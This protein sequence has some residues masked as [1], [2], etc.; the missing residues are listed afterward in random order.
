M[1][2]LYKYLPFS[3]PA[4]CIL[5]DGTIKFSSYSEFNDPFDCKGNYDIDKS[6]S[7]VKRHPT[8]L[9]Q[10][11]SEAGLSPAQRIQNKGKILSRIS[12]S[13]QTGEHH[14]AIVGSVGICCLSR[15]KDQILMWSHY[16]DN[17]KGFVVEFDVNDVVMNKN[18]KKQ[19]ESLIGWDIE[20]SSS[21]PIIIVGEDRF[22]AVKKI[23]LTKSLDWEYESEY[24]A[25]NM[26]E[27]PG[28]Y[29][30]D[31][32]IITKVIAGVKMSDLDY[33]ELSNLVNDLSKNTG[34]NPELIRATMSKK[35][36]KLEFH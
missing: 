27:G 17:H 19:T 15:K 2:K 21:M 32:T 28:V 12:T 35:E 14:E 10:I 33:Q 6:L 8:L 1:P 3:A 16:A 18:K 30:F 4:K 5:S 25:L 9:K 26:D 20:Y 29:N 34:C 22:D 11:G 24:R 36:Y 13:L 7:Y 31:Q 23:F